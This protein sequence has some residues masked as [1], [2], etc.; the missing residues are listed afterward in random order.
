MANTHKPVF[1]AVRRR[2]WA[3]HNEVIVKKIGIPP[4]G[5]TMGNN[6]R[7]VAAAECGRVR[8]NC[9]SACVVGVMS[10]TGN[11]PALWLHAR[12][13]PLKRPTAAAPVPRRP[14]RSLHSPP[15]SPPRHILCI[16]PEHRSRGETRDGAAVPQAP[17]EHAPRRATP[18]LSARDLA[19]DSF[20]SPRSSLPLP[21]NVS[22]PR[23]LHSDRAHA[24]QI[25][26]QLFSWPHQGKRQSL[27]HILRNRKAARRHPP[28]AMP[29]GQRLAPS[30]ARKRNPDRQT[31]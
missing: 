19:A 9:P 21:E 25:W 2:A 7:N 30:A 26:S 3:V 18:R 14:C 8:R 10:L 15:E 24:L 20:A 23:S 5:S 17:A 27:F 12:A 16:L 4:K 31:L 6:A 13:Q 28:Y 1:T 11:P 22:L 29:P